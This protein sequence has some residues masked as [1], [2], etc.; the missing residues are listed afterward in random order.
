LSRKP[1]YNYLVNILQQMKKRLGLGDDLEW[2]H[3]DTEQEEEKKLEDVHPT[4][5]NLI[6]D[7][8][9]R[10]ALPPQ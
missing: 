5:P 7:K 8:R 9:R 3:L 4:D 6:R 10:S 1:D 2:A